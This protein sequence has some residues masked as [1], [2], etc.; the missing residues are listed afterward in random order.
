MKK[1]L[2]II[3]AVFVTTFAGYSAE[4]QKGIDLTGLT[5][6][7]ASQLNQLV[8]NARPATNRGLVY[9]GTTAPTITGTN[10]YR[11]NYIWVDI[12]AL[13]FTLRTYQTG[14]WNSATIGA[15][16][17]NTGNIVDGAVTNPKL[18]AN[19][20]N[21]T[22]ISDNAVT[23]SKIAA[24][25]VTTSKIGALQVTSALLAADSVVTAKIA[26]GQVTAQKLAAGAVGP[27]TIG[28]QGI[29]G[30]NLVNGTITSNL[31]A[32]NSINGTN[33]QATSVATTNLV[34]GSARYQ[35]WR[36]N[37][38]VTAWEQVQPLYVSAT[39]YTFLSTNTWTHALPSTPHTVTAYYVVSSSVAG[40]SSG[41]QIPMSQ[42]QSDQSGG[43][44]P[45]A[46]SFTSTT[47]TYA[48]QNTGNYY[49]PAKGTGTITSVA[50][51]SMDG[52]IRL[53]AVYYNQ[54]TEN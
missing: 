11:T 40:Y 4:L 35:Q 44:L 39:N 30:T 48:G 38:G 29:Y 15:N 17:V 50:A 28:A 20:V 18:A 8:D 24:G 46:I 53:V 26:D 52:Q 2:A 1:L 36:M 3:S 13:P 47:L 45:V 25:A 7:T 51:A 12:S 31:M 23:E 34:L 27:S 14:S 49:L 6:V 16:S 43:A 9:I 22:N 54:A 5:T 33:I 21:T 19:A 32:A 10:S 42:I 37:A 41:D